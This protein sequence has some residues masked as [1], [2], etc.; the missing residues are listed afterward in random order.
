MANNERLRNLAVGVA[1]CN[2]AQH[3]Q[4]ALCKTEVQVVF[5]MYNLLVNDPSC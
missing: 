4:F 5:G 1:L 2:Q 3:L